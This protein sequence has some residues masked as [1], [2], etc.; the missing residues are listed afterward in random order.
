MLFVLKLFIIS[1]IIK[2]LYESHKIYKSI[3]I[4][5]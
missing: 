1:M 5:A 4:E 2:G 3:R